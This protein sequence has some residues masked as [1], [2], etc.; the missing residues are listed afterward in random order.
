MQIRSPKRLYN[1]E[2]EFP[3]GITRNVRVKA[4]T[5]EK[6]EMRALKFHPTA[7]GVKRE[8]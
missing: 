1:I 2:V 7:T 5:R 3:N 6:A 8:S 4:V